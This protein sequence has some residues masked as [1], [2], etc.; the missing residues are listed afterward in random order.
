MDVNGTRYHLVDGAPDWA[1]PLA[2]PR[3]SSVEWDQER[4]EVSLRPRLFEFPA[5]ARE[6]PQRDR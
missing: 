6:A 4:L 3:S 1:G 2:D 5:R